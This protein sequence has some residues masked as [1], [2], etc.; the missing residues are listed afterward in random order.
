MKIISKAKLALLATVLPALS[1]AE[2]AAADAGK[3]QFQAAVTSFQ[4]SV[5]DYVEIILT[6][7]GALVVTVG[8]VWLFVKGIR[9]LRRVIS[10]AG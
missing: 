6:A 8:A 10:G 4:T 2:D 9:W 1:F 3:A 5:G 7:A